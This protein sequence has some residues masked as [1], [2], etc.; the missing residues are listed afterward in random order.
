MAI[1]IPIFTQFI[2]KGIKEA[3][4]AFA[5]LK[6]PL[7]AASAAIAGVTA[8]AAVFGT[9][10][11][12]AASDFNEEVSKSEVVFGAISAEVKA[13]AR[14]AARDLGLSRTAALE[15]ANTF[16]IFGKSAGLAGKEL[17]T[18]STDFVKL[19]SDLSSFNNTSVDDAINAIGSALRGES[20]PL[21]RYGV[22]LNDAA[23]KAA[24]MELGIYRGTGALTSQQKVLAAQKVIY[25][26][27][28]DAQGDFARTSDGLA[29]QM[30]ILSAT[31]DDV[32]MNIGRALIPV[33]QQ[34]VTWFNNHVTPAVERV[35]DA[36][37]EDGVGAGVQ[38]M[39]AEFKKAG[40]D[41]VPPLKAMT[42]AVAA[43]ANIVYRA[44]KVSS[45][46]FN[47]LKGNIIGAAG[48]LK[49]ALTT[50]FIDLDQLG[51]QFDA[52]A[53]GVN[54]AA[55]QMDYGSYYAKRFA[56]NAKA[57]GEEADPEGDK[58]GAGSKV[59][60]FSE[61]VKQGLVKSLEDAQKT[62]KD[63][64]QA[65]TDF[66]DAVSD[67]ITRALDFGAA[68][69]AGKET[70]AGFLEGLRKQVENVAAYSTRLRQLLEMGLSQSAFQQVLDA[71]QEAGSAIAEQLISG[72]A[73]A[74]AE[75]NALIESAQKAADEIG[76]QSATNFMT[77]G[78]NAAQHMVDGI[79]QKL[80]EL[81]PKLMA[82]MDRLAAQMRRTV[83][84][85]VVV[86][87]RVNRIIGSI[88]AMA[89]GGIVTGP[90]LALI[91]E[92]GPEAVV[93]LSEM[94]KMGGNVTVNVNGGLSSSAEIGQAVVNAIR[95]YNRTSGP[96][97]IAVA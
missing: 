82:Q 79:T 39:I 34:A 41:I 78:V 48:D 4:G 42:L 59:K 10:A 67:S 73:E 3:Q 87:E 25:E 56:E 23:L 95:A 97:N 77:A 9:K 52:F 20:E 74:I 53:K 84:I 61:L 69:E 21:R 50:S 30:K 64:K 72:G 37:G 26:Q 62:L 27:T 5:K 63:A 60:R 88:P 29:G 85:D 40:I 46:Q 45:A 17:S 81:T 57:L 91:G 38:Q 7:L 43:F 33:V 44:A 16:A 35:A 47:V 11:V 89:N 55:S 76:L 15:A 71:G 22:L 18:F 31:V 54:N 93:P 66:A 96:A 13:F 92:A 28:G 75:T 65:F 58:K 83:N 90:T 8:V 49:D 94:G 24:A 6:G 2:D 80:K 51:A 19:A 32:Q 70:G 12:K 14:T 1:N 86:T 68:Q 36:L